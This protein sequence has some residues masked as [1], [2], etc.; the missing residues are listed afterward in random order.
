MMAKFATNFGDGKTTSFT[1]KHNLSSLDVIYMVYDNT[2]PRA[3][4]P[5]Q[6]VARDANSLTFKLAAAPKPN[7]Y[8]IV[9]MA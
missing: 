4:V 1:V 6:A 8:R 2:V 7:E 5:V 3:D 9:V